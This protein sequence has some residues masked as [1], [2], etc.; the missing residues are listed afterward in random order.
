M[1]IPG[2]G[3]TQSKVT[4]CIFQSDVVAHNSDCKVAFIYL[5]QPFIYSKKLSTVPF[6]RISSRSAPV[7]DALPRAMVALELNVIGQKPVFVR[8]IVVGSCAVLLITQTI[9]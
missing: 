6:I 4:E 7:R 3:Y 1:R 8:S 2:L 5:I 9:A